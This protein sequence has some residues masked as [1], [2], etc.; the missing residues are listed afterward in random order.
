MARDRSKAKA[1]YLIRYAFLPGTV[2]VREM[3]DHSPINYLSGTA[4]LRA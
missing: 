3:A 2:W 1:H 4:G